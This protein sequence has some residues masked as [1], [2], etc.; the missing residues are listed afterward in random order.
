MG[1]WALERDHQ[2]GQNHPKN[3]YYPDTNVDVDVQLEGSDVMDESNNGEFRETKGDE[4]Q[5]CRSILALR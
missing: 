3:C 4:E 2:H 1:Q 5:D